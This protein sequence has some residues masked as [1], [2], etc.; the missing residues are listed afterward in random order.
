V[1]PEPRVEPAGDELDVPEFETYPY[2]RLGM[3]RL[4][5]APGMEVA[6]RSR[7]QA[8]GGWVGDDA[9]L[10]LGDPMQEPGF[11]LR[12]ARFGLEG[13]LISDVFFNLE[14][15]LYD[16]E[17]LGG[18]LYEAWVDVPLPLNIGATIGVQPLPFSQGM[19][20]SSAYLTHLDRPLAVQALSPEQAMGL[21]L[22]A[23][24]WRQYLLASLGLFNGIQRKPTF[25]AGY[26]GVGQT[27]GNRL[28]RLLY[29]AKLDFVPFGA[30]G[31]HVAD[32]AARRKLR[33]GAGISGF[34]NDGETVASRSLGGYLHAK[35][36]G[37]HLLTEVLAEHAEP[38]EQPTAVDNLLA[39]EVDRM[40][41]YADVGYM[42]VPR[43]LGAA[44]RVEWLDSHLEREDEGDEVVVTGTIT[45]FMVR[46]LVKLVLEASHREELYGASLDN[47]AVLG[48]LQLAF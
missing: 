28:E 12:R 35:W 41:A 36:R 8:F 42:I 16:E 39:G 31:E 9:D 23:P 7:I 10:N 44:V 14:V 24:L 26:Q 46:D 17:R 4:A 21:V 6:L 27:L 20:L 2:H 11:R 25:L 43:R 13:S 1:L 38:Q 22:H 48:G 45:Y 15:D 29:G 33:L 3:L 40:A 30:V 5:P 19:V 34:Y 18:P 37:F 32:T 47:D